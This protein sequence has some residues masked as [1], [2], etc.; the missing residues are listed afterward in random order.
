MC[1]EVFHHPNLL[2]SHYSLLL[3]L[4]LTTVAQNQVPGGELPCPDAITGKKREMMRCS[5]PRA[6]V[7]P[8]GNPWDSK[9]G[10]ELAQRQRQHSA[11]LGGK[12]PLWSWLDMLQQ[13]SFEGGLVASPGPAAQPSQCQHC[14]RGAHGAWEGSRLWWPCQLQGPGHREGSRSHQEPP[15]SGLGTGRQDWGWQPNLANMI[16]LWDWR[17][18][19]RR[20]EAPAEMQSHKFIVQNLSHL[21]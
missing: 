8:K 19:T 7:S 17:T 5:P 1:T 21:S 13:N 15:Q 4:T 18:E 14:P 11:F 6:P 9:S 3:Q 16:L 20:E 10:M 2:F 12:V